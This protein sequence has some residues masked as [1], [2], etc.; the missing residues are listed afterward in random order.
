MICVY[1]PSSHSFQN[2]KHH[3]F[4]LDFLKS[5]STCYLEQ[6]RAREFI[7]DLLALDVPNLFH[8]EESDTGST[9]SV[10]SDILATSMAEEFSA[11]LVE[12]IQKNQL[13]E[14]LLEE[15]EKIWVGVSVLLFFFGCFFLV[16]FFF[17][18]FFFFLGVFFLLVFLV[19][20]LMQK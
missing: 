11:F 12:F 4:L 14:A 3:K 18:F 7:L 9:S 5:I 2:S 20:F 17:W 1:N 15:T 19:F 16:F 10:Q 8:M 6:E 13:Q